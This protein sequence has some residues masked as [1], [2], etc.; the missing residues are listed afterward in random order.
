MTKQQLQEQLKQ[1]MLAKDAEKTSVLRMLLSAVGYAEINHGA[2]Y[3][4]T[5]EDIQTVIEKEV[6]QRRDSIEQFKT[7]G[8]NDLAEK[9]EKELA[10]L[11]A[12]LPEQMS[13]DEVSGLVKQAIAETG[14][15]S[16]QDMGK[17]MGNLMPKTKGKADGSMISRIVRES[18]EIK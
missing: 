11:Q 5:K 2:G 14:A 6:K 7:G 3:E 12:Y 18:L 4:A 1:S 15:S 17:V 8:R 16:M 9:E 13:E 10:I